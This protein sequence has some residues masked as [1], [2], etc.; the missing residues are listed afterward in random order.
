VNPP[1]PLHQTAD[2]KL[3]QQSETSPFPKPGTKW[4]PLHRTP[5]QNNQPISIRRFIAGEK[6]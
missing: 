6:K 5:H 3:R 4:R 2:W 1:K